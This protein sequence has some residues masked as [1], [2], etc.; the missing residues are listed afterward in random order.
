MKKIMIVLVL[1]AVFFN[2]RAAE[3]INES[4]SLAFSFMNI[5]VG[6][7]AAGMGNAFTAISGD[8]SSIYWNPAGLSTI[9]SPGIS[10]TYDMMFV[11]TSYQYILMG[12]PVGPGTFGFDLAYLRYGSFEL[13]DQNGQILSGTTN[14]YNIGAIAAYGM[15]FTPEFSAGAAVKYVNQ[16]VS[17]SSLTGFA[18]DFGAVM[19]AGF[20][21]AG[22][23]AQNIGSAG[24]FA[25]PLDIRAGLA[26]KIDAGEKNRVIISVDASYLLK[27]SVTINT[28]AEYAYSDMLFARAG[29]AIKAEN[30]TLK[31]LSGLSGGLGIK[32]NQVAFDYSIVPYG[33]LGI[34]NNFTLSYTFGNGNNNKK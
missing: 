6:A 21:S 7:R 33:E 2:I 15:K 27:G 5:G 13:R 1:A 18:F 24:D 23:S 20:L 8:L 28:G 9:K 30:S 10:M 26:A 12:F 11:D 25:V 32:L 19:E 4:A 31:G 29:Y 22:V 34:V 16:Q 3:V 14:P 17:S